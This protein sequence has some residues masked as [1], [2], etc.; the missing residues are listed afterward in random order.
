MAIHT[1]KIFDACFIEELGFIYIPSTIVRF[2]DA[3][4]PMEITLPSGR[5]I[6]FYSNLFYVVRTFGIEHGL[7]CLIYIRQSCKELS[8]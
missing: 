7:G 2:S 6:T 5:W 8:I 3:S 4:P 1:A